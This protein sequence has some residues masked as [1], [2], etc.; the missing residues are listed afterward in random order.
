MF[1]FELK[2]LLFLDVNRISK[3]IA[4]LNRGGLLLLISTLS[5]FNTKSSLALL[6]DILQSNPKE[7]KPVVVTLK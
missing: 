2:P 3:G 4:L 6:T 5:W 1:K 7:F